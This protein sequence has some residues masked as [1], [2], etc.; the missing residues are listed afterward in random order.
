LKP[1]ERGEIVILDFDPQTGHEQMKRR[2]ALVL[3]PAA[4]NQA[5]RIAFV[6]PITTKPRGHAFEIPLPNGCG[7][8]GSVLVQQMKSLDWSAR[9]AKRAGRAPSH[10]VDAAAEIVKKIIS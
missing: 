6:A 2:P 1:P 7:A 3:S 4:F 8:R 5:F 10:V 9:H